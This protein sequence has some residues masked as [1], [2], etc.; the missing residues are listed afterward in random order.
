MMASPA[1]RSLLA[2]VC[3]K[4][5][6]EDQM[7][8]MWFTRIFIWVLYWA[9]ILTNLYSILVAPVAE[10]DLG[11]LWILSMFSG[12]IYIY[13]NIRSREDDRG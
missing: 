8:N 5:A 6:K 11:T 10:F 2:N 13:T 1:M 12:W 9:L 4:I 3:L 7:R